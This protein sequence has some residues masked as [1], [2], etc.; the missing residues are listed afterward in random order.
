MRV[1]S[2]S[3]AVVFFSPRLSLSL[4]RVVANELGNRKAENGKNGKKYAELAEIRSFS[5]S[6]DTEIP[7]YQQYYYWIMAEEREILGKS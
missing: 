2:A 6:D 5:V 7:L 3:D 4:A 1:A